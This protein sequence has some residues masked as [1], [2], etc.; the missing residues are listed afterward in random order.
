LLGIVV[1]SILQ[2]SDYRSGSLESFRRWR[3]PVQG[4]LYATLLFIL[5]M[6]TSNVPVQFIYFQF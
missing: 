1:L 6:G 2:L 4:F 3:P 5:I